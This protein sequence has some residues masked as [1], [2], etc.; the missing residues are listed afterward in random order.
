[1]GRLDLLR[2][3]SED[4]FSTSRSPRRSLVR[5]NDVDGGLGF[6]AREKATSSPGCDPAEPTILG[7]WLIESIL[8]GRSSL[9]D[10]GSTCQRSAQVCRFR[11]GQDTRPV[12][13][14]RSAISSVISVPTQRTPRARDLGR[15]LP[16]FLRHILRGHSNSDPTRPDCSTS[17]LLLAGQGSASEALKP[18]LHPERLGRAPCPHAIGAGQIVVFPP[19]M[20]HPSIVPGPTARQPKPPAWSVSF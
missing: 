4:G 12:L 6:C 3:D 15:P 19:A 1:M 20:P 5:G 7:V 16:L 13:E 14:C 2:G 18:A 8:L 11:S 17:R 9:T 10:R